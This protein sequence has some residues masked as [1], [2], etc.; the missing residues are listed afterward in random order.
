[1]LVKIG[2]GMFGET[3]FGKAEVKFAQTG[4]IR[5]V[6]IDKSQRGKKKREVYN[7]KFSE[8]Q[9]RKEGTCIAFRK[10]T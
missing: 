6:C 9:E 7:R 5:E 4:V 10:R 3:N 2:V 1:M 8:G